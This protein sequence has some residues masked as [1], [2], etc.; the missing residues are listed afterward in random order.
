MRKPVQPLSPSVEN[1][2]KS[3]ISSNAFL[4]RPTAPIVSWSGPKP[5]TLALESTSRNVISA[6]EDDTEG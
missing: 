1:L 4:P 5:V 2:A 6:T 3:V